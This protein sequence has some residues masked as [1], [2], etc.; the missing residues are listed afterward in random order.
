MY[1]PLYVQIEYWFYPTGNTPAVDIPATAVGTEDTIHALLLGCADSRIV[2]FSL[3][4]EQ[5]Y[6]AY[7]RGRDKD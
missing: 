3:W 6:G 7:N 2:L 4:N 5:G 1:T